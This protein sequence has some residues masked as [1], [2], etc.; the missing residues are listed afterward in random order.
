MGKQHR[1]NVKK[2][3]KDITSP[4]GH[5]YKMT[6]RLCLKCNDPFGSTSKFN[7]VCEPC[8]QDNDLIIRQ[9]N[10][11]GISNFFEVEN[12]AYNNGPWLK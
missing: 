10:N 4:Y 7:K 3:Q 8:N 2:R 9:T 5:F 1:K 12:Q 6:Q 11:I